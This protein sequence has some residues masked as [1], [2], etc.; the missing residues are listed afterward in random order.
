VRE[1]DLDRDAAPVLDRVLRDVPGVRGGAARDH[2][3]LVDRAQHRLVDAQV[4]EHEPAL[5]VGPAEERVRD[6]LRLVVDLLVHERAEAALLG[7]GGVP[8]DG[9]AP[10]L[11]GAA[12]EVGDLDGRRGDRDDLVLPELERLLGVRDERRDVGPEEVLAVAE[13]HDQRRVV[14]GADHDV[15][16]VGVHREQRERAVQAAD[17]GRQRRGEVGGLLELPGDEVRDDLGVGLRLELDPG[18]EQLRLEGDVVLDDAVV[19]ERELADHVRVRVDVVRRAVRGPP[20]VADRGGRRAQRLRVEHLDEVR[21]LARLLGAR[22]RA[23]PAR[24]RDAGGVVAPVLEASQPLEHDVERTAARILAADVSHDSAHGGESTGAHAGL[25]V[26]CGTCPRAAPS[27]VLGRA[28]RRGAVRQNGSS[29]PLPPSRRR[30]RTSTSTGP[31]G[32]G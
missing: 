6:G 20:R 24:E 28:G 18:G 2:D 16:Q 31:R 1:L 21:E 9:V 11:R 19:D 8:V 15:G 25:M 5:E 29:W 14:P 12:V 32:H 22:Q 30:P 26:I 3:D 4:V 17:D 10:A 27:S 23:V 13:P 7:G